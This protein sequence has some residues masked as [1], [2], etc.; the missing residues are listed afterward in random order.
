MSWPHRRRVFAR[1]LERSTRRGIRT[2]EQVSFGVGALIAVPVLLLC[3]AIV[4]LR[5]FG[6]LSWDAV[7]G[8]VEKWQSEHGEKQSE[9]KPSCP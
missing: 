4:A 8:A 1:L 2:L 7:T 6:R 9:A 5:F 3:G